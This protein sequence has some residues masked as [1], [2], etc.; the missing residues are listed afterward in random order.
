MGLRQTVNARE[1][2]SLAK[3]S[4]RGRPVGLEGGRRTRAR[5]V[6]DTKQAFRARSRESKGN[7]KNSMAC[8][9]RLKGSRGRSV[10][11]GLGLG[12]WFVSCGMPLAT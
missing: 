7:G 12:R 11:R 6:F 9:G 2:R 3:Y 10:A 5:Q 8:L 1:V 4:I